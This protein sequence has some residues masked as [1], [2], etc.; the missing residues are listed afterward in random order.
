[1]PIRTSSR[2]I[3]RPSIL[4]V[5]GLVACAGVASAQVTILPAT[6]PGS[7]ANP[8]AINNAGSVVGFVSQ[9]VP[10]GTLFTPAQWTGPG[11]N[12]GILAAPPGTPSGG[13]QISSAN[14]LNDVGSAV[15]QVAWP[16]PGPGGQ[17]AGRAVRW[18]NGVPT[19]LGP[20][21]GRLRSGARGINNSGEVIGFGYSD[22]DFTT[23]AVRWTSTGV[24]QPLSF[25]A[26]DHNE[27]F[28]SGINNVGRAVGYSGF[29][30]FDF[31]IS[32][33]PVSWTG[34][35][36]TDLTTPAGFNFGSATS[37][38]DAGNIVGSSIV[39]DPNIFEATD[40]RATQWSGDVPALLP[41]LSGFS[42]SSAD[43]INASGLVIGNMYLDSNSAFNRFDGVP[44]FW[45]NGLVIDLRALLAPSFASGTMFQIS[46]LNDA[47]QIV[48]TA[49]TPTGNFGF[50]TT[51]PAPGA[52][53]LLA[54]G[55]LTAAKR[56]RR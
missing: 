16:I 22:F 1:V 8:L 45:Q 32:R 37:I 47:G 48:G 39:F 35:T 27:S 6:T 15:G 14:A 19:D 28:A 5:S 51:I 36:P 43:Q 7:Y 21:P 38:N 41:L 10:T 44:V 13:L 31:P 12:L 52:V 30:D 40:H 42:F 50:V 11:F 17:F 54:I 2:V 49:F 55:G 4:F 56:R 20:I 34:T 9:P 53:T 29:L 33:R 18:N 24:L 26:A 46:D 23:Q 25:L 3:F